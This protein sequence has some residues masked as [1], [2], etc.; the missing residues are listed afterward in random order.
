MQLSIFTYSTTTA[1]LGLQ[2]HLEVLKNC[3]N[4]QN[5]G[6]NFHNLPCSVAGLC[7]LPK[8]PS[9]HPGFVGHC[10]TLPGSTEK[11]NYEGRFLSFFGF[12]RKVKNSIW[13]DDKKNSSDFGLH[14]CGKMLIECMCMLSADLA[15]HSPA[16]LLSLCSET[17]R[18]KSNVAIWND[19]LLRS[20]TAKL[21]WS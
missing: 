10:D 5:A 7:D 13:Q 9:L 14:W 4:F 20:E 21:Q 16:N 18:L 12:W 15:Q 6:T 11:R 8:D 17:P 19:T 2:D 1:L 3:E